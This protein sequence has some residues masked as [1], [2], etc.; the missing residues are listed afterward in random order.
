MRKTLGIFAFLLALCFAKG[1]AYGALG[2]VA[3]ELYPEL[4][5]RKLLDVYGPIVI[6]RGEQAVDFQEV[7]LRPA[8]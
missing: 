1:A 4:A 2:A 5:V 6:F 3:G 7:L 8:V